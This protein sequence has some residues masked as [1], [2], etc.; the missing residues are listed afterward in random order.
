MQDDV[1][2]HQ[3]ELCERVARE[4]EGNPLFAELMLD[5]FA[6]AVPSARVPPTI[7]A[8]LTTRLDQLSA[9]E[10]QLLEIA[11]AVGRDFS[12]NVLQAMLNADGIA[13]RE[14]DELLAQLVRRR[15]IQRVSPGAFRFG[16]A[17]LHDTTYAL[18]P[19]ARRE[20]WHLLL[21]DWLNA[22]PQRDDGGAGPLDQMAMAYHVEAAS[23]LGRELRPGDPGAP[24]LAARAAQILAAEGMKA[25]RRKDLPGAAALLERARDL[26]PAD[27]PAQTRLALLICDSR[28]GSSDPERALTALTADD[29]AFAANPAHQIVCRIQRC[30]VS[31]RLGLAPPDEVAA[32][33]SQIAAEL[34]SRRVGDRAWC[35]QFQLQAYLH[36]AREHTGKAEAELRLALERARGMRDRYE[37]ERILSAICEL[38]QWT[39]TP[40]SV[41]LSLC[42]ELSAQFAANRA[43]LVPVLLTQ[44]RLS[45]L[46]DD[47]PGAR[48]ALAAVQECTTDL[49]LDLANAAAVAVSGIV[50]SL[51]EQHDVAEADYRRVQ[52]LLLTLGQAGAAR[53]YQ[54]WA[55]R[56]LF[57]QG[58]V[59]QAWHALD[60][61]SAELGSPGTA[62]LRTRIVIQALTARILSARGEHDQAVRLATETARSSEGTDDLWLQ[63]DARFDLAVVAY[64]AGQADEAHAAASA[65]LDRYRARGATRLI[66]RAE[67]WLAA[68]GGPR[69]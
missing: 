8:L 67:R 2:A 43:L 17:L 32:A 27:D 60:Q 39:P 24:Q 3:Q 19:K 35:R 68:V 41:G 55:A 7:S 48:R 57:E 37:E 34:A 63:G 16:Q 1:Y 47:L 25:L 23:L 29:E 53:T 44:A 14:A 50:A 38:S 40:V 62:D 45:A 36:L 6:D 54:A 58:Q 10:R 28:L 65:A 15:I 49:H 51:G 4:C 33:A 9:R 42:A 30:I 20:H 12:W 64:Q 26:L 18:A 69:C 66:A 22:S 21:A 31:L 46:A 59:E 11:A 5:V 52:A 13:D 56:E 61:L